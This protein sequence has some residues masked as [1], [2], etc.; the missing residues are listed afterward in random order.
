[1]A[2]PGRRHFEAQRQLSLTHSRLRYLTYRSFNGNMTRSKHDM[3][4][5]DNNK[6]RISHWAGV[7]VRIPTS[8]ISET[9]DSLAHCSQNKS[10]QLPSLDMHK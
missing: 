4:V 10:S 1:M 7:M 3:M 8:F 2:G 5:R 6:S 9:M